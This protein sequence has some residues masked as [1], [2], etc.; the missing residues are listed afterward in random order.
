LAGIITNCPF[1]ASIV[2]SPIFTVATPWWIYIK[3]SPLAA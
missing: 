3:A 2:S 1:V